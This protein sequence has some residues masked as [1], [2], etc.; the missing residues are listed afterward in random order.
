MLTFYELDLGLN[1]VTRKHAEE[2]DAGANMLLTV[3]G[4]DDGPG[5]VLVIAEN[6][7]SYLNEVC[8]CVLCVFCV[9]VVCV[10]VV[11]FDYEGRDMV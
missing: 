10:C 2:V 4:G 1:H 9:S 3:P 6:F 8:V 5:G 11:C 7:V